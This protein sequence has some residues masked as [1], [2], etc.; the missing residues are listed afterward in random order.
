MLHDAMTDAP[1]RRYVV[2]GDTLEMIDV[3]ADARWLKVQYR[4]PRAGVVS[5]WISVREA[6]PG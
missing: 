6:T 1:T 3:S 2:A 4:N 5:G